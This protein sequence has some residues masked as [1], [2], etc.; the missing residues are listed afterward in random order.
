V[1]GDATA[2]RARL[3]DLAHQWRVDVDEPLETPSSL[4]AYGRRGGDPVVLKVVKEPGDEWRSG[5]VAAA[6]AGRGMVTVLEYVDG[7]ALLERIVPGT[8]LVDL[9]RRG[10]DDA[11]TGVLAE[12]I[13]AMAPS[14]GP[15]WCPRV[16]EDLERGFA[17]YVASGDTQ[18]PLPLVRRAAAMYANLCATQR[19]TRLLH[20]DLQHYNVLEDRARGWI[21]IDPK[22]VVAELEYEVGAAL[23]NP[24]ELPDVFANPKTIDRRVATFASALKLD[25]DRVLRWGFAEGVLSAIWHVQDGYAIGADEMPLALARAIEALWG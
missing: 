5:E 1:S 11:A 12:V 7:A 2:V 4:I 20:A 14:G 23:R 6:F 21:A 16:E 9:V 10:D 22:G 8:P 24:G 3:R 15:S 17:W 25:A 18:I 13:A 19:D